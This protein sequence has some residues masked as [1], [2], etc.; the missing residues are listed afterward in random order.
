MVDSTSSYLLTC[1]F[2][3]L[4]SPSSSHR[5]QNCVY[6]YR[7]LPN[8]DKKLSVQVAWQ[9]DTSFTPL[10]L[11]QRRWFAHFFFFNDACWLIWRLGAAARQRC[12]QI[13][14]MIIVVTTGCQAQEEEIHQWSNER[15]K[16]DGDGP[17]DNR[18]WMQICFNNCSLAWTQQNASGFAPEGKNIPYLIEEY[19]EKFVHMFMVP[20]FPY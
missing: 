20:I 11:I 6:T 13:L 7:I 5:F 10:F 14:N 9:F 18:R 1:L 17:G 16:E 8:E 19:P 2:F 3:T 4:T 15:S 12:T